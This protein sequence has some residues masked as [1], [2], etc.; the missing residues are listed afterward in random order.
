MYVFVCVCAS[1]YFCK[2]AAAMMTTRKNDDNDW[3]TTGSIIIRVFR[4][5]LCVFVCECIQMICIKIVPQIWFSD[6]KIILFL[7]QIFRSIFS[8]MCTQRPTKKCDWRGAI[9]IFLSIYYSAKQ[10]SFA[11]KSHFIVALIP[12]MFCCCALFSRS[13]LLYFMNN[14]YPTDSRWNVMDFLLYQ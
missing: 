11:P 7:A 1:V 9:F 12:E 10:I 2:S 13:P 8:C 4:D 14:S 5:S 6:Q 3:H